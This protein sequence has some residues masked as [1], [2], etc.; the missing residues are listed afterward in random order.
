MKPDHSRSRYWS[1]AGGLALFAV[2]AYITLRLFHVEYTR[3]MGSIE[4]AF[5]SLAR[6]IRDH[7]PNL[8]WFPLWYGG[9][10]FPD[11]YPPI[12]PFAVAG[13]SAVTGASAALAYHAIATSAYALAPVALFWAAVELG[14]GRGAGF[15]AALG[16]S[17][18]SPACWLLGEVRADSG[19]WFGPRR[20]VALV[21][22]GEGPHVLA[23]LFLP[24]AVALLHKAL[25]TRKP[26]H[27]VLAALAMSATV[28]SN[29]IGAFALA[30][31]VGAYLLSAYYE[32]WR[33]AWLRTGAIGLYAYAL[34]LPWVSPSTVATIRS[35]A[36]LLVG[37]K[38]S[39]GHGWKVA[40]FAGGALL[41]AW[42][43]KKSNAPAA[44]RF[45]VLFFYGTAGVVL[46]SYWLNWEMLPQPRR[47]MLEMDMAFW[48]AATMI[49]RPALERIPRRTLVGLASLAAIAAVGVTI[50]QRRQA[51]EM[52]TPIS[53]DSTVEYGVS[54][55]LGE[56]L[57]GRRVFAPGSIGFW[58]DAFS[59]TPMLPGGF[60]NGIRNRL[61]WDVNYQI[62]AGDKLQVALDWLNAYGCDAIV[63]NDKESQEA[64]HSYAHPE[65]LHIL[66]ELWRDGPEVIYAVPRRSS[67]LAHAIRS[68]DLVPEVPP[69]YD[70]KPLAAYLAALDDASLPPAAF[71]W[72][73]PASATIRADLNPEL[74]LSVQVTW[75]RGW[76]ATVN[77]E[78][79]RIWAD[80]LGQVA[81][82]PR[83]DG[84][85]TVELKY[86]AG[87]EI[88][89]TRWISILALVGGALWILLAQT[90]WRSR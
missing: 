81:I 84:P 28:L 53:I 22:Y 71:E 5:I 88:G 70:T 69:G 32:A 90:L 26:R 35:N 67:S 23:L 73:D 87:L 66:A 16:Y 24:L 14:A 17:L 27:F 56:H 85:C 9:I 79:R 7:F 47:Y 42:V 50:V 75:D 51:R 64:F 1:A 55:W 10:P 34:A 65:K 48:L 77:G 8:A 80:K 86:D 4:A 58:M 20:L 45:G 31:A 40:A 74:L 68:S 12:L 15:A 83:C 30:L 13:F 25:S 49:L 6:Y 21:V 82:A 36:A 72:R 78:P 3:Q 57:P 62:L 33:A 2:N 63:G 29:W 46:S 54:R 89:I 59:D 52:E 11:T 38:T 39:D 19:G 18:I 60:D 41:V 43:L 76:R 37:F 44:M 61:L